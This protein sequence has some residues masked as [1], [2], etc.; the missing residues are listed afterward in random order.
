MRDDQHGGSVLSVD[1]LQQH[2]N[3][4]GGFGIQRSRGFIAQQ[5]AGIFDQRSG[6]GTALLLSTGQLC[7]EL[8]LM[9][10]ET[11]YLQ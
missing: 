1:I 4:S 6:N 7:G 2:Q 3:I 11:K 9:F 10:R 5:K 8:V